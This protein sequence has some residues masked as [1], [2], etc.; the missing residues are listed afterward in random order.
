MDG[1]LLLVMGLRLRLLVLWLGLGL[2]LVLV[3]R[4]GGLLMGWLGRSLLVLSLLLIMR[5]RL[6]V[7][8]LLIL[9]LLLV[10]GLPRG[11]GG[12]GCRHLVG[13]AGVAVPLLILLYI[14]QLIRAYRAF[15]HISISK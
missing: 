9:V 6:L 4:L 12:C 15:V 11:L 7:S 2:R 3:L 8:G 1:W 13:F 10:K 14:T 5:L